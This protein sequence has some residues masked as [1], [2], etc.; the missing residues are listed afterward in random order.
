MTRAWSGRTRGN[1]FKWKESR[2]RL[3]IRKKILMV[4]VVMYG[5]MLPTEVVASPCLE[6]LKARMDGTLIN[7]V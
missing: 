3:H 2:L 7:L 6:M 1:G 5:N 4:R